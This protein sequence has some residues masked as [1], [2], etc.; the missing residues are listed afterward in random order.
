M[1]LAPLSR[2][3]LPRR[4]QTADTASLATWFLF[5]KLFRVATT[6]GFGEK[7][8]RKN[9]PL[10][11]RDHLANPY[12]S[13]QTSDAQQEPNAK[14]FLTRQRVFWF[15]LCGIVSALILVTGSQVLF[16]ESQRQGGSLDA[17]VVVIDVIAAIL[18]FGGI[19]ALIVYHW[20]PDPTR[21]NSWRRKRTY[22]TGQTEL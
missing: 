10:S 9:L 7:R 19:I 21:K 8:C 6:F 22:K 17:G 11:A 2:S 15:G 16:V 1:S 18:F 3:G 12:K 20:F 4:G 13:P 14:P 5:G